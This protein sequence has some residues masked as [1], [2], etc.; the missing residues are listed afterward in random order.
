[1]EPKPL[2][3][4]PSRRIVSGLLLAMIVF[5]LGAC[6]C[7]CLEHNAWIQMVGLTDHHHE[8]AFTSD[9]SSIQGASDHDCT[10][11]HAPD[12]LDNARSPG[13]DVRWASSIT[14]QVQCD[15]SDGQSAGALTHTD[16]LKR[17]AAVRTP[18][19]SVLQIFQ[20]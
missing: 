8:V 9:C 3:K 13:V 20:I 19:R 1:M 17:G 16:G 14:G 6:P 12:Y 5:Q 10:G 7:G 15:C 4:L 11:E 2:R 18:A